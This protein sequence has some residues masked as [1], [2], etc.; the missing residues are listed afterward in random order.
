M[1]GVEVVCGSSR[2]DIQL[3][4]EPLRAEIADGDR[5]CV[6]TCV[7]MSAP[8]DKRFGM[9]LHTQRAFPAPNMLY[10]RTH[11]NPQPMMCHHAGWMEMESPH[12]YYY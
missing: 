8:V 10:I 1:P 11:H 6:R 9:A 12:S 4:D 5:T 7:S 2:V 3:M